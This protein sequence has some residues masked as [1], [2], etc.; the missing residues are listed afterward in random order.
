MKEDLPTDL[1]G[2]VCGVPAGID[3]TKPPKNF[4]D[5]MK[6]EDRRSGLRH[7]IV[8]IRDSRTMGP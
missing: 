2:S 8:S 3:V 4:R 5:V 1:E 7:M 6:R